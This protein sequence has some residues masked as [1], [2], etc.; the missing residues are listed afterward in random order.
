[1]LVG[2]RAG[3]RHMTPAERAS[4]VG[5]SR[6]YLSGDTSAARFCDAARPA[7]ALLLGT[8]RA[9]EAERIAIDGLY[10]VSTR[11]DDRLSD[12]ASHAFAAGEEVDAAA[13]EVVRVL[14]RAENGHDAA[15]GVPVRSQ[16]ECM[17]AGGR[18][19][20]DPRAVARNW[21]TL[22]RHSARACGAVVKSDAYG[23]GIAQVAP[24][25]GRAGCNTFFVALP[26]EGLTLR[27][28]LPE[29]T[30]YILNGTLGAPSPF[31][32]ARLRPFV[33]SLE[34]LSE[35]PLSAPFALNVDT[36]MNRLGLA[37]EEVG[38]AARHLSAAGVRP[39]LLASH[40]ACADK[41]RHPQNAEQEKAF[42]TARKS[43]P[44]VPASL[45]NSAAT[46]TRPA[47]HFAL[48]RPGIALYGGVSATSMP[49]LE[50]AVR[51]EARV[52]QVRD[53]RAGDA[54][55]YGAA[56]RLERPVRLAIASVG[57]GDG[58]LRAAG[59]SDASGG[60][61][62]FVN[63]QTVR[64]VGR[65]SMDLVTVDVTDAPCRRGDW[66]ELFGPNVPLEQVA[67]SAGTIGYELLTGLSRRA[68]RRYGPL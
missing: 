53:A 13:R 61:P 56:E 17:P 5:L 52:V 59:A 7:C 65:L 57:Y 35:W 1:M 43:F 44:D 34:A 16:S 15:P 14:D 60:A 6:R 64:L 36:G 27:A 21:R 28:I 42:A 46:L 29:A 3:L 45:A 51:L 9:S 23:L 31:A 58:F 54:V 22:A 67:R 26:E 18:I 30:I 68:E 62:A 40:F 32:E 8:A 33:S 48:T 37:P 4:L 19:T 66:I 41:P 63:G 47:S 20:I 38:E 11:H 25:L 49:P 39:H 24:A 2:Q 10:A 12:P 55:G 50:P